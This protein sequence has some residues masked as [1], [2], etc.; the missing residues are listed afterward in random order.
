MGVQFPPSA[1]LSFITM[2]TSEFYTL[3]TLCGVGF[4]ALIGLSWLISLLD[5]AKDA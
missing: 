5:P 3:S 4:V 2:E 1:L